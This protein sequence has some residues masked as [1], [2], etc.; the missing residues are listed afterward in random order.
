MG[1]VDVPSEGKG[2]S[3][4]REVVEGWEVGEVGGAVEDH[5]LVLN[6]GIDEV[7]PKRDG[8]G[9]SQGLE[10]KAHDARDIAGDHVF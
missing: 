4:E 2:E 10:T 1:Q 6:T 7:L 5:F 9:G 8:L 3:G